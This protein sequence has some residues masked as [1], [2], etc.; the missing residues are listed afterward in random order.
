MQIQ[1]NRC[2][3]FSG[4]SPGGLRRNP[5]STG[6]FVGYIQH[7]LQIA[8]GDDVFCGTF[9]LQT[10]PGLADHLKVSPV[11]WDYH[12]SFEAVL[13]NR[14]TIFDDDISHRRTVKDGPSPGMQGEVESNRSAKW[15]LREHAQDAS[16]LIWKENRQRESQSRGED[17]GRAV[18][19]R[20]PQ[21]QP[22]HIPGRLQL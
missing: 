8:I 17:G 10:L 5:K 13:E 1:Q 21:R 18:R 22:C 2:F 3:K 11:A 15:V 20:R 9:L 14:F 4:V 6:H 12:Q 7:L 19:W 16:Q